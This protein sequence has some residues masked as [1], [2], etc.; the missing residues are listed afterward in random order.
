MVESPEPQ[1]WHDILYQLSMY[2][3]SAWHSP[4]LAH[5]EH[6]QLVSTIYATIGIGT[7]HAFEYRFRI[8]PVTPFIG[9]L[10]TTVIIRVQISTTVVT[11]PSRTYF[12]NLKKLKKKGSL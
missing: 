3:G 12:H 6:H 7:T 1:V 2:S 9:D 5:L 4:L 8:F 11:L 10:R